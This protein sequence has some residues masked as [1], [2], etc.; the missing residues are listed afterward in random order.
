MSGGIRSIFHIKYT[1]SA[2]SDVT[3]ELPTGGSYAKDSSF[4]VDTTYSGWVGCY[5]IIINQ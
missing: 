2:P 5:F 3:C 4:A 1:W